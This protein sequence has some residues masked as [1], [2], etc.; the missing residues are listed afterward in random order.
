[1]KARRATCKLTA[2]DKWS[3]AI[4]R[5]G[6]K[7]N[8]H[9]VEPGLYEVGT[10]TKNSPVFVTS[11][12]ILSF[13]A[14]RSVLDQ[15]DGYILVL[16]TKGVNVWCAAGEGTFSTDELIKR[17]NEAD[18]H[19]IV[20]HREVI[21][22]QLGAPGVS[23]HIVKK[24]SKFKVVYGPVRAHDISEYLET[25]EVT[26]EMRKVT[27]PLKDRAVLIPVEITRAVIPLVA[28]CLILYIVGGGILSL[29]LLTAAIAGIVLFPL[30]LPLF[31]MK[32]FCAN[33]LLLGAGVSLPFIAVALFGNT[34]PEWWSKTGWVLTYALAIPPITAYLAFNFTGSTTFTSMSGV[35]RE[36]ASYMRKM[37][38]ME[39]AGLAIMI[40]TLVTEGLYK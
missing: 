10:P 3:H 20:T 28:V 18:L 39:G 37:A 8:S 40:A 7:R 11:N 1:M 30:L 6:F 23:A 26:K 13:D 34:H 32:D 15:H 16:D 5:A 4:I 22:P 27:F 14:L 2:S 31:P 9:H 35:K 12:Y 19:N 25:G 29:A 33:G 38:Y 36:I 21:V 17:I 24:Q